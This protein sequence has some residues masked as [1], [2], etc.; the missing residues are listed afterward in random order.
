MTEA[1]SL[2]RPNPHR[3]LDWSAVIYGAAAATLCAPLFGA[4]LYRAFSSSDVTPTAGSLGDATRAVLGAGLGLAVGG[5]FAASRSR[6]R[7]RFV[8][9]ITAGSLAYA[10]VAASFIAFRRGS[11][12]VLEA[13]AVSAALLPVFFACISLGAAVGAIARPKKKPAHTD[14]RSGVRGT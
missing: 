7:A 9:G 12:G 6:V 5:A 2:H 4:L 14:A 11:Y 13:V 1:T 8:V 3:R 10:V